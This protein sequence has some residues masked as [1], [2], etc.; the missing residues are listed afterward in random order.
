LENSEGI[1][2]LAWKD[3]FVPVVSMAGNGEYR[4]FFIRASLRSAMPVQS[5]AMEDYDYLIPTSDAPPSHYSRHQAYLDKHF[6]ISTEFGYTFKTPYHWDL[7]LFGGFL[8]RNRKWSAADGYLQYPLD[9]GAWTGNE[10]HQDVTGTVISYE[11]AIWFPTIGFIIQGHLVG[12]LDIS[13]KTYYY[14]YLWAETVDTHFL[15]SL[16]FYDALQGGI[17]GLGEVTIRFNFGVGGKT[18]LFL[19]GAYEVIGELTGATASG[20]I[21]VVDGSLQ[22]DEGYGSGLESKTWH[23]TLGLRHS[24]RGEKD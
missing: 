13:L 10:P 8:Y 6:D 21:G 1:S 19:S 14:P 24:Y 17:G 2:R 18:A 9:G 7:S 16:R 4:N 15:R 22:T 20:P 11:Q 12:P 3:S 23:I 5:G